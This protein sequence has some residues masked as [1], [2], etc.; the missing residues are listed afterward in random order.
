MLVD[1]SNLTYKDEGGFYSNTRKVVGKVCRAYPSAKRFA[2]NLDGSTEVKEDSVWG[3]C[4]RIASNI[5]VYDRAM[6]NG[7]ASLGTVNDIEAGCDIF[8]RM[9]REWIYDI[10]VYRN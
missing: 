7:G 10:V 3:E 1:E 9:D 6:R 5:Y 4:S 8:L 2:L